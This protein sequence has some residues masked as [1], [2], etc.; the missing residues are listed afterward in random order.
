M[1][2]VAATVGV[3]NSLFF[4][5]DASRRDVTIMSWTMMS[6]DFFAGIL[7]PLPTE[8]LVRIWQQSLQ[9]L[10]TF[11]ISSGANLPAA[12]IPTSPKLARAR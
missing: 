9:W 3:G 6:N 12:T 7:T 4:T 10:R 11:L 5:V 1:P 2:W 8:H